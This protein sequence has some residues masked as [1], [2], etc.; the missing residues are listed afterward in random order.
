ML[1]RT[2]GIVR[3]RFGG[4][5]PAAEERERERRRDG[6]EC[7]T[8]DAEGG[9]IPRVNREKVGDDCCEKGK[10]KMAL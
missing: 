2:G 4:E 8:A 5:E 6:E 10:C 3:S 7:K 1:E 9:A